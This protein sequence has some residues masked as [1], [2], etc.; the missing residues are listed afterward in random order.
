MSFIPR[1]PM[2]RR[3]ALLGSAALMAGL[4]PSG[5]WAQCTDNFSTVGVNIPNVGGVAPVQELLPL[6]RGSSLSAFTATINTVN[7][8]FLTGTSAF[9]SAPGG[10]RPDQQG[11]GAW[12]RGVGGTAE[13]TTTSTGTISGGLI[14]TGT[15]NCKTTVR[16]DY[17]GYQVG[18]DISVLNAAGTGANI[19]FGVTAGY[20]EART[21]DVT[22]AGA[23]FNPNAVGNYSD[24]SGGFFFF[25]G[26]F[27]T[28]AGSFK[29]TSQVP[30]VG[31]YSAFT[32]GQ[33]ALDGQIRWDFYQNTLSDALNG[34]ANQRHDAQGFSVTANAAYTFPLH[35]NW[36]I[37]PSVGGI[38][39]RV[40]VDPLNVVGLQQIDGGRFPYARGVVTIDDIESFLGRASVSVGTSFSHHG[41]VVQPYFTAS[42]FHEFLGDVTA[43]SLEAGTGNPGIDGLLLTSTSKGGIGTYGQFAL[44]TAAVFGNSGWLGYGRVDYRTGEHIE[45][46]SVNAGLRYQFTPGG[47]RSIKDDPARVEYSYN[48]TGPYIGAYVGSAW[49]DAHAQ[50]SLAAG[51]F[52]GLA[53]EPDFAGVIGGGQAGYNIQIGRTVLGIEGEYGV[54]NA[55]GGVGCP[56]P[57]S[58]FYT[59][60]ADL[61]RLAMLTGRVGTTWGRALFYAKAGLAAGEVS[62][63]A[64]ENSTTLVPSI[65]FPPFGPLV[66][67]SHT[68]NW[69][70]GWTVGGG[71]EF[72]LTDRW[73]A[74]AEYM[75]YDLG[76]D[77]FTTFVGDT[78]TRVDTTG[79]VVRV[80]VNLHFHP[81]QRELPLK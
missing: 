10:P 2:A 81:V 9:V 1:R 14:N 77:T 24:G 68:T 6:G 48:W 38:W 78:G 74:R 36:F 75:H 64:R 4:L 21:R 15:Q 13:T 58:L 45:G 37:E 42:V 61:N 73:S 31:L 20:L 49:G 33:L 12:V 27:T 53:A 46:W 50:A 72:A 32:K 5:G 19:H 67:G 52:A 25:D 3:S 29:E 23:Y 56:G 47:R 60:E 7:T 71:M 65:L 30:F 34:L 79:N 39:S 59:C 35:N 8:A 22:P 66:P 70:L 62:A 44:G 63:G 55:R 11:G 28:P 80:G 41:V 51:P 26:N 17:A 57:L 69:Q 43:R 16:Q 40:T 18:H 54:S 76:K